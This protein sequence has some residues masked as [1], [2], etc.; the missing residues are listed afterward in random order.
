[1][2]CSY[3]AGPTHRSAPTGRLC[4]CRNVR[5]GGPA[6]PPMVWQLFVEYALRSFIDASMCRSKCRAGIGL[7]GHIGPPLR[8]VCVF[9]EMFVGAA[10]RGRPWN[11]S[12]LSNTRCDRSSS[13]RMRRSKC[14]A[15]IGL[16]RHIG[17]PLRTAAMRC[18]RSSSWRMC[19]SECRAGLGWADT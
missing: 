15:G 18:F 16:G 1:M 4:V 11:D 17:R 13:W 5:R 8:D 6:W 3:Y 19:R 14:R 2:W 10:L 7:G 9:A 12:S